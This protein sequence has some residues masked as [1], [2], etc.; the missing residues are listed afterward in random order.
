MNN[1]KPPTLS[2]VSDVMGDISKMVIPNEEA[3]AREAA[4]G[5]RERQERI[6][7][8]RQTWNAPDRHVNPDKPIRF[9][10]DWNAKLES[11]KPFIG[12]GMLIALIG[13]SGT[14]KTQLAVQLMREA[15]AKLR[16]AYFTT[17]IQFYHD[18]EKSRRFRDPDTVDPLSKYRTRKLLVIDE[19]GATPPRQSDRAELFDVINTRYN[20]K[21]LDTILIDNSD[22]DQFALIV[23]ASAASRMNECGGIINCNWESFR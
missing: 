2:I 6:T 19:A 16:S 9:E 11:L 12:T 18:V 10:G 7:A 17:A 21:V 1:S 23:G 22:E 15:T 8:L 4:R 3:D 20:T 13:H 5:L 14:G